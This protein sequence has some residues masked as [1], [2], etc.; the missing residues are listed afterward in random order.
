[1]DQFLKTP[2]KSG[3]REI[4]YFGFIENNHCWR[5]GY[6]TPTEGGE[7]F[8]ENAEQAKTWFLE[9]LVQQ[10]LGNIFCPTT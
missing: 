10:A 6:S 8:P 4:H 7:L 1:M 3:N 9:M 5:K 2:I